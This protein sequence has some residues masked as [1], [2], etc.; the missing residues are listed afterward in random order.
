MYSFENPV[1]QGTVLHS[2]TTSANMVTYEWEN[3]PSPPEGNPAWKGGKMNACVI[4]FNG[5]VML[6]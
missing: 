4:E 2:N 6:G 3:L 5:G 1:L